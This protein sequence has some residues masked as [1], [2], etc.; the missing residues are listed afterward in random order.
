MGSLPYI[1]LLG[2][3]GSGKSTIVEKL[4]GV[5]GRSSAVPLS[6]T[7]TAEVFES[8]DRSFIICDTPGSNAMSEKI[9]HNIE[10]SHA[11]NSYPVTCVL[12]IVKADTRMDNVLKDVRKYADG[13]LPQDIPAEL[14]G[15]CITHMDNV[16]WTG[17]NFL[18][19]LESQLG[20][21]TAV[22][23]NLKTPRESLRADIMRII[24]G[25]RPVPMIID[26]NNLLKRLGMKHNT[27]AG[28]KKLKINRV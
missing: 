17:H 12:I 18:P 5:S 8:Y 27:M 25:K 4:T 28:I 9:Q 1:V 14:I 21:N 13:F 15:V 24:V 3:V 23:S 22:F 20:I 26:P 16:Q 7:V 6:K 2:D 10:I 11:L 19:H